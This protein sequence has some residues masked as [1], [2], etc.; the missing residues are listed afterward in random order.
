MEWHTVHDFCR[1]WGLQEY[2]PDNFVVTEDY[3]EGPI[4]WKVG[5]SKVQ[6]KVIYARDAERLLGINIFAEGVEPLAVFEKL[7]PLLEQEHKE[8][9]E[10]FEKNPV[11]FE[12]I[13]VP[14]VNK[15]W[16]NL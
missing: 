15:P 12:R 2:I 8:R 13:T 16:P 10:F 3:P 9:L 6:E 7:Q 11:K 5:H 1:G 14:K 4:P